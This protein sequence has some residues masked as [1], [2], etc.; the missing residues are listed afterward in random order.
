[1]KILFVNGALNTN[2]HQALEKA[3]LIRKITRHDV[4]LFHNKSFVGYSQSDSK[5]LAERIKAHMSSGV[6]IAA[7]SCGA[8]LTQSA[9]KRLE[10]EE[11]DLKMKDITVHTFGPATYVDRNLGRKVV[12]HVNS[13]DWVMR[14]AQLIWGSNNSGNYDIK[15]YSNPNSHGHDFDAYKNVATQQIQQDNILKSG[16]FRIKVEDKNAYLFVGHDS[17]KNKDHTVHASK[18]SNFYGQSFEA[19][20]KF[21]FK[22]TS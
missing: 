4:E 21:S 16:L 13:D 18:K 19:R 5:D 7:H 20:S 17:D 15:N 2:Y 9:L 1:M 8:S 3:K 14:G 10:N 22:K 6:I 12:N 11:G